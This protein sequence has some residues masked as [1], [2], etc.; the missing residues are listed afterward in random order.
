[1]SGFGDEILAAGTAA[2]E[3]A[4]QIT[5]IA[6]GNLC[7]N[8]IDRT[9]VLTGN[10]RSGWRGSETGEGGTDFGISKVAAIVPAEVTKANVRAALSRW[11]GYKPF[12]LYND[13]VYGPQIEYDGWSAKAP[14]GMVR[15]SAARWPL[16]VQDAVRQVGDM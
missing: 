1:M 5:R 2:L 14:E 8:V 13:V 9:P 4:M 15:I 10:L 7:D 16:F 3:E 11:D 6:A 12:L